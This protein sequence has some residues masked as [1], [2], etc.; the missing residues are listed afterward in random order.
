MMPEAI[1]TPVPTTLFVKVKSVTLAVPFT[2]REVEYN[3][4]AV[5]N[6]EIFAFP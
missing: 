1:L 6:P 2:S 5:A 4:V 3:V